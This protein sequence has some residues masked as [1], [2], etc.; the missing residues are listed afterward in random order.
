MSMD[1]GILSFGAY[2]PRI[3]IER[4]AIAATHAWAFPSLKGKGARAL[5]NWDED[6]VTMA[7][8]AARSLDRDAIGSVQFASTT[9]PFADLQHATLVAAALQ[10]PLT[11]T[12]SDMSGS[13][14]SGTSALLLALQSGRS[15]ATLVVA[16][17]ARRA[18][19][20]SA[21]EMQYGAGGVAMKVGPGDA[22]ARLI[23][24]ASRSDPFVDHYRATHADYD[25]Q[26]EER[27]V[28]E[29]GYAKLV[30]A[31][32]GAALAEAGIG[33][34]D[35]ATFC[36]PT[37]IGG[38][39]SAVAKKIGVRP[40]AIADTLQADC[41]DTGAAHG[42]MML[43][44]ALEQATP[45]D[46]IVA[47]TFGAGC[48]VLVIEATEA[49]A[50]YRPAASVAGAIAGGRREPHYGKL[51]SFH[52]ELDLDWGMRAELSEKIPVTQ[53]YRSRE[54][55]HGFSAGE[56]GACGTVQFPQLASC[57]SCG[58]FD[59]LSAR[60][61][62]DQPAKLASYTADWLQSYPSP[63]LYFGLVQFDNGAR[64]LMELVDVD[65]EALEV[66]APLRMVY[67]IKS[68]DAQR[69]NH[70]YFWKATPARSGDAA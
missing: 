54:Q 66:G 35:V 1:R 31:A 55:L 12:T 5:A 3:R 14:R 52:G 30:P 68:K 58:S 42:L 11:T 62:A 36:L 65:A 8:E 38:A 7:V 34:A 32:V 4:A 16:A 9:A 17:D 28:R 46:R 67:R 25:Y 69:S 20:G 53:Q 60:P 70:R 40:E 57:V 64:V 10:L 49:I 39:A 45:G 50:N 37:L 13:V 22:I 48:D 6:A 23:G 29:E 44:A 21:Q 33:A 15:D 18:K 56:C 27:W 19:P 2:V 47:V 43:A 41:G 61:L 51:L 24:S 59:A 26:W 63:P